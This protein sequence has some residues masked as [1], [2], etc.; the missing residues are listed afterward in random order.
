M[1]VE[2]MIH[3]FQDVKVFTVTDP[4]SIIKKKK[5]YY[6]QSYK[7]KNQQVTFANHF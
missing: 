5:S 3:V 6:P 4:V 2:T 7:Q 1:F